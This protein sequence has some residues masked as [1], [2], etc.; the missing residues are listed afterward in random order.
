MTRDTARI[1]SIR[2]LLRESHLDALVCALPANVLLLTGY[3][4]VVGTSLVIAARAAAPSPWSPRTSGS[5]RNMVGPTK[6]A[7]SNPRRWTICARPLR[8][9]ASRS[10]RSPGR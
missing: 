7:R 6:S 4:P 8:P 3:W 1:D 9:C 10:P 5:W 2:E